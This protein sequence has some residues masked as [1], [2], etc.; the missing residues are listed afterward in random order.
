M[1]RHNGTTRTIAG[2][3]KDMT[4]FLTKSDVSMFH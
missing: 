4:A 2:F 3:H 1:N